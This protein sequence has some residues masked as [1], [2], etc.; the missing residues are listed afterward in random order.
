M[1]KIPHKIAVFECEQIIDIPED[2]KGYFLE[3]DGRKY[4]GHQGSKTIEATFPA[5]PFKSSFFFDFEYKVKLQVM[6]NYVFATFIY[7]DVYQIYKF[8][9][10]TFNAPFRLKTV[11]HIY[12]LL[13]FRTPW[14]CDENFLLLQFK[15]NPYETLT[16]VKAHLP[17]LITLMSLN[18]VPKKFHE[19][20]KFVES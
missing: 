5:I 11:D 17:E 2:E 9:T 8:L 7:A 15:H 12:D 14:P 20:F 19:P 3:K 6:R 18:K 16:F 1:R 10:S 4:Y 13:E